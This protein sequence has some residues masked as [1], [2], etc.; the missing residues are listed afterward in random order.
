[1][2]LSTCVVI[3]STRVSLLCYTGKPASCMAP[4]C[5]LR[6]ADD[7]YIY[8][9][10]ERG[11]DPNVVVRGLAAAGALPH[12]LVR[13]AGPVRVFARTDSDSRCAAFVEHL[14]RVLDSEWEPCGTG[15]HTLAPGDTLPVFRLVTLAHV[16]RVLRE[17]MH[18]LRH[19]P[20]HFDSRMMDLARA[21][22]NP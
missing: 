4:Q 17:R 14:G 6:E 5:T 7:G 10:A 21:L 22:V 20:F 18:A 11:A 12:F 3:T 2:D 16:T 19:D 15:S 1:M 9:F 8:G 13:A